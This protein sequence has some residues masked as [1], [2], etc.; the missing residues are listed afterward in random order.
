MLKE[1]QP[2]DNGIT[3]EGKQIALQETKALCPLYSCG[4]LI[5]SSDSSAPTRDHRVYQFILRAVQDTARSTWLVHKNATQHAELEERFGSKREDLLI[6]IEQEKETIEANQNKK[7][8]ITFTRVFPVF[9]HVHY[10]SCEKSLKPS[11]SIRHV[12]PVI[13][14]SSNEPVSTTHT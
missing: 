3:W 7:V 4:Q 6:K 11:T 12:G 2:I 5:V 9:Y 10:I 13:K 14:L 8:R 1:V